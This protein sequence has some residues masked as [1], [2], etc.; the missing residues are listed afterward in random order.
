[1]A[2][3]GEWPT[4]V[5]TPPNA[6][7]FDEYAW[8]D[9]VELLCLADPDGVISPSDVIDII[10]PN[11]D[12]LG[13]ADAIDEALQGVDGTPSAGNADDEWES[14]TEQW[15]N[16]LAYR[17]KAF[18]KAYP[19]EFEPMGADR[20]GPV[21]RRKSDVDQLS[22]AVRLYLTL[23]FAANL[24][25]CRGATSALTRGFE[26]LCYWAL[27]H[28]LGPAAEVHL[29]GAGPPGGSS[30]ALRY[31]GG[32]Y[33]KLE[34]L[35]RDLKAELT[36]NKSDWPPTSSG[37][38]GIDLVGWF[39]FED[40]AP[41]MLMVFAQCAATEEWDVKQFSSHS[42]KWDPHFKFFASP[43]N[44]VYVPLCFRRSTGELHGTKD[45]GRSVFVDRLRLVRLLA[46][47]A[48]YQTDKVLDRALELAK[49]RNGPFS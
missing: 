19:F 28:Q 39:P 4:G 29:F 20:V 13:G 6:K 22:A 47:V 31:T 18:G 16:H 35:G 43:V 48:E 21:L 30:G 46:N 45:I 12:D 8:A 10:R 23:L 17:A 38:A 40:E 1:M 33:S 42:A 9:Y 27:K 15:F 26:R 37:D 41:T 14:K 44:I 49:H 34:Q 3:L 11:T 36:A 5:S 32:T 2:G 7:Q 25:Y 24:R